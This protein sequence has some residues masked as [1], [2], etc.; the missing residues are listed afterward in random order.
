MIKEAIILAG[1]FGTR[2]KSVVSDVPK[3]MAPV[4]FQPFLNYILSYLEYFGVE[5]I[6]LSTGYKEEKIRNY[7]ELNPRKDSIL[8]YS[9]ETEPLGTGGAIALAMKHCKCDIVY[10]LNGDSFFDV[11]LNDFSQKHKE[12]NAD[13]SLSLRFVE[14]ASRYGSIELEGNRLISFREKSEIAKPGLINGGCYILNRN[15]FLD[16]N[17]Q[18]TSFS[19]EKDFFEKQLSNQ[20]I[21]GF[22]YKNQFIDI[23]TPED[24]E[25]AQNEFKQ[26][27]Y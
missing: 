26:F 24:F 10:A 18:L 7:Y 15:L 23:G 3:P 12:V 22:E 17:K 2:L 25:R 21:A 9:H 19:I 14:N 8:T 11:D 1:G 4:V 27:K 16:S 13:H 5:H 20:Y 6:I